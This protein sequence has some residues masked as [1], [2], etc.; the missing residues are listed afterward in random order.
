MDVIGGG[1]KNLKF[2]LHGKYLGRGDEHSP[3]RE[4]DGNPHALK[5]ILAEIDQQALVYSFFFSFGHGNTPKKI[6]KWSQSGNKQQIAC[7][8]LSTA[9]VSQIIW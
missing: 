2:A 7:Q 5:A 3:A 9:A 1:H 4:I 8:T 6:G